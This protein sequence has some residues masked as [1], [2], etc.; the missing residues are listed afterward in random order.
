MT[1]LEA[2]EVGVWRVEKS[3]VEK[4]WRR[5]EREVTVDSVAATSE[6]V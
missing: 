5:E 6:E 3:S 2:R 4:F 1:R